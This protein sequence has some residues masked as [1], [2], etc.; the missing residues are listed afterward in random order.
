MTVGELAPALLDTAGVDWPDEW[1]RDMVNRVMLDLRHSVWE[2][3]GCGRCG[4]LTRC[5]VRCG[6]AYRRSVT[7]NSPMRF[8]LTYL[9]GERTELLRD[10]VTG[11]V[12]IC[13]LHV[14][15]CHLAQQWI[16]PGAHRDAVVAPRKA[17]KSVFLLVILPLWAL[18][19]GHRRHYLAL[20]AARE[21]AI[22]QVADLRAALDT[23]P[24]LRA[25]FPELEPARHRGARNSQ[26]AVTAAGAVITAR[27]IGE[28][29]RGLRV[30]GA[31]PDLIIMDDL[32]PDGVDHTV[33]GKAK[34][35]GLVRGT[36]LPMNDRAAVVYS[37]TVTAPGD[38][39]HDVV[40]AA[41]GRRGV[42][43]DHG[44]WLHAEVPPF[45]PR[46]W[47]AIL[48]VDTPAERS[49][50]RQMWSLAELH[51]R[52]QADPHQFALDYQG[53]PTVA[54]E[55]QWWTETGWRYDHD[56][57]TVRRV[58]SIDGAVTA[59]RSSDYSALVVLGIDSLG[60]VVC[61]EHAEQGRWKHDV[62]VQKV[63][64]YV[65]MYPKTLREVLVEVDQ[66]G[67]MWRQILE[68]LDP[69]RPGE[70]IGLAVGGHW[71]PPERA[72]HCGRCVHLIDYRVGS[73]R[74][75]RQRIEQL[76]QWHAAGRWLLAEPLPELQTA[77]QA[78]HPGADAPGVDDMADALAAACRYA[79]TGNPSAA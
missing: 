50:W 34:L 60:Q 45:Q 72:A 51:H 8:A 25:D 36:V 37:G 40:L 67:D 38:M 14:D 39:S 35:V 26:T 13:P 75:K 65:A 63:R 16:A 6:A 20:S 71:C 1:D 11:R 24:L 70:R 7:V 4:R 78:W 46:H 66:G 64:D 22:V 62:L 31:R 15:L 32:L 23:I 68:P 42:G 76:H 29:I 52:R 41:A 61:V 43:P 74:S 77:L 48:D 55:D 73:K 54:A 3:P 44:A 57:P 33:P 53:D 49:L 19:H 59:K 58:L 21:Q 10:E 79:F 18:A 27:G 2:Q 47:P 9:T 69:H 28:S 30:D 17:G 56:Y 12:S 5:E